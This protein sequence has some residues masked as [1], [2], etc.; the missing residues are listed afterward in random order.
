MV[1]LILYDQCKFPRELTTIV[2]H[3]LS[4]EKAYWQKQLTNV[5]SVIAETAVKSGREYYAHPQYIEYR[6]WQSN[7]KYA[8]RHL[9]KGFVCPDCINTSPCDGDCK[10]KLILSEL[11]DIP[12]YRLKL[13]TNHTMTRS[14]I[15]NKW[16]IVGT[17]KIENVKETKDDIRRTIR[18]NREQLQCFVNTLNSEEVKRYRKLL[19]RNM[20][21]NEQFEEY[22][23]ITCSVFD[24]YYY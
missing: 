5:L 21:Y 6:L 19:E 24:K 13:V 7:L 23:V 16:S 10:G 8:F 18:Q 22:D 1:S 20:I 3:Y 17:S 2:I 15:D 9:Y 11:F 4:G 14:S 12:L